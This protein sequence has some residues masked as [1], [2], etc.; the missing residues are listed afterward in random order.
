V[1]NIGSGQ[2]VALG[3]FARALAG[4]SPLLTVETLPAPGQPARMVADISR[5]RS[6]EA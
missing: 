1:V 4:G 3:D 5:L 6:Q 2:G